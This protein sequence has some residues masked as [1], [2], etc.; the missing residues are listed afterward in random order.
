MPE[1]R[2]TSD[3]IREV[4]ARELFVAYR[5]EGG[6]SGSRA[7]ARDTW[8]KRT[9]AATMADWRKRAETLIESLGAS[10]IT[11]AL[12]PEAAERAGLVADDR[13]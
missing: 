2:T 12:D 7:H 1:P 13:R 10:N 3:E 9:P 8:Y 4:V 5:S 11:L 6:W